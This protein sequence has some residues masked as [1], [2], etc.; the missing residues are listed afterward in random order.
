MK[1]KL[2]LFLAALLPVFF[3]KAVVASEKKIYCTVFLSSLGKS[4][5]LSSS[6]ELYLEKSFAPPA[7]GKSSFD[8]GDKSY[9][10]LVTFDDGKISSLF[11][12]DEKNGIV[13]SAPQKPIPLEDEGSVALSLR[14]DTKEKG[15]AKKEFA[16]LECFNEVYFQKMKAELKKEK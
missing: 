13:A 15:I 4:E 9:S 11:L 2:F 14:R 3:C 12:R 5:T 1:T 8:H 16:S 10:Y 7:K 6:K